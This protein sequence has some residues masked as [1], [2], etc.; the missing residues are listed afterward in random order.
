MWRIPWLSLCRSTRLLYAWK[1]SQLTSVAYDLQI[2]YNNEAR[3]NTIK[4]NAM[5]C[6]T[7]D[8]IQYNAKQFNAIKYK[9]IEQ[10]TSQCNVIQYITMSHNTMQSNTIQCATIHSWNS[11]YSINNSVFIKRYTPIQLCLLQISYLFDNAA[12]VFFAVFVSFWGKNW[13]YAI[14]YCLDLFTCIDG[15]LKLHCV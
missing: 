4:N 8:T 14:M 5:Q 6:K 7:G 9:A 13:L 11:V 12:T 1:G 10:N 3:Y 2:Q 15:Y